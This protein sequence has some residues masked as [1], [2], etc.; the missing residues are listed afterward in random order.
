VVKY[1]RN[2]TL[3]YTSTVAPPYPLQVDTSLNTVYAGVYNVV[4][5]GTSLATSPVKYVL[6]DVQGSTRAV[7]SGTSVIARHDFFPFG[8]EIGAWVGMRT[9]GQG[10][11]AIDKIRQ[12][13]AMTE[14]DDSTGL[15]HTWWR[16][17]EN[18]SGR[19]T[20]PDPYGGSMSI[21][22]PQSFNR[23]SYV[24]NDPLNFVDPT[25]L[26]SV[27]SYGVHHVRVGDWGGH[28]VLV[29]EGC[30]EVGGGGFQ[31][32]PTQRGGGGQGGNRQKPQQKK[33]G[34]FVK[35]SKEDC[36]ALAK[37]IERLAQKVED[38]A[39]GLMNDHLDFVVKGMTEEIEAH[40]KSF[41]QAQVPLNNALNKY[42]KN[43]KGKGPPPPGLER[44]RQ[45][46]GQPAPSRTRPLNAPSE[47]SLLPWLV[48]PVLVGLTCILCPECCAVSAPVLAIP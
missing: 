37:E 43:C 34:G 9:S 10:F 48:P 19:W 31:G 22:N 17:Y 20:S 18:R 42:D 2:G 44:A 41:E 36:E 6:Q 30:F 28:D 21:T 3:L 47:R 38:R 1:Y 5:S 8:E 15:D 46:A 29:F 25:G 24:Q 35:Y 7:M 11:G 33:G 4:I 26:L 27:C 12:R 32:E 14:R 13:Y 16:K 39:Q 45:L 23:Y 40:V